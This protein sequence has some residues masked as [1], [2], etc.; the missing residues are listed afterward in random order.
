MLRSYDRLFGETVQSLS[1]NPMPCVISHYT[2]D[3]VV[4][5]PD[6]A[7]VVEVEEGQIHEDCHQVPLLA[8]SGYVL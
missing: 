5:F 2:E 6:T 1:K 8:Y 3:S 4:C 7:W